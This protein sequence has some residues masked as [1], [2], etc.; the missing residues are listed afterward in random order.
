M[1]DFYIQVKSNMAKTNRIIDGD[2]EVVRFAGEEW[3]SVN[4]YW[5]QFK[6][7]IEYIANEKLAFVID[8]DDSS[9]NVDTSISIADKFITSEQDLQW[10][11]NGIDT[12]WSQAFLYPDISTRLNVSS[13][14]KNDQLGV[15]KKTVKPSVEDVDTAN[16]NVLQNYYRKATRNFKR[17]NQ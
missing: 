11:I 15:D 7:K 17:G 4:L 2:L 10:I 12:V 6:N 13:A 3:I 1:A 9:F 14:V 16:S 8:T 5:Q